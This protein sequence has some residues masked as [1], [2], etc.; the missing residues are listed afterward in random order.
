MSILNLF[1]FLSKKNIVYTGSTFSVLLLKF[2]FTAWLLESGIFEIVKIF[3]Y[4]SFILSVWPYL[5]SG[6]IFILSSRLPIKLNNY[7]NKLINDGDLL[8][9]H[10]LI[11]FF[12]LSILTISL[13]LVLN[14][15]NLFFLSV[16][17]F[18]LQGAI[19]HL[20]LLLRPFLV[21][22]LLV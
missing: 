8:N 21:L 1:K 4:S 11:L 20:H 7:N 13:S 19:N 12:L 18:S 16:F 9:V 5:M 17:M 14:F 22:V 6:I 15:N 2:I 10:S 3:N